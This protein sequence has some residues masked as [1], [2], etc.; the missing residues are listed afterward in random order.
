MIYYGINTLFNFPDESDCPPPT[1]PSP[2]Y[3]WP[4]KL[5]LSASI[6]AKL[7][8]KGIISFSLLNSN[9]INTTLTDASD[10]KTGCRLDSD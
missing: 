10:I 2:H 6:K 3:V 8:G 7:T 9:Y 4:W 5:E 1:P